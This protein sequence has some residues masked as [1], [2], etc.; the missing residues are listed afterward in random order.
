MERRMER[1]EEDEVDGEDRGRR[2]WRMEEEDKDGMEDRG[3]GDENREDGG[4][5][6]ERMEG[7][8]VVSI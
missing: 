5:R 8:A 1:M 2:G 4:H 3:G 7:E 6:T